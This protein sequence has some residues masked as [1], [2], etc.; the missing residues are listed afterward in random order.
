MTTVLVACGPSGPV[1]ETNRFRIAQTR[2]TGA[3]TSAPSTSGDGGGAGSGAV[4]L[5][6]ELESLD[7]SITVDF[8]QTDDEASLVSWL[9]EAASAGWGVVLDPAA[10]THYSYALRDA[11]AGV[12]AVGLP[13]I[14]VHLTNPAARDDGRP[15]SVITAVATAVVAGLGRD[16]YRFA[17]LAAAARVSALV[18]R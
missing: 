13:L 9:H 14:E 1:V 15:A 8:R 3:T 11:A 17:V 5:R 18:A 4:D 16:S 7:P 2:P 10:F 12:T 6:T